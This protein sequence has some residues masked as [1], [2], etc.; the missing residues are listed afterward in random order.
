MP[1][2]NPSSRPCWTPPPTQAFLS[3]TAPVR[4][5]AGWTRKRSCG[6]LAPRRAAGTSR[7]AISRSTAARGPLSRL[8]EGT[9][10][11]GPCHDSVNHRNGENVNNSMSRPEGSH[12]GVNPDERPQIHTNGGTFLIYPD[13]HVVTVTTEKYEKARRTLA[14]CT[15][16][17][18]RPAA[19]ARQ[20]QISVGPK[21]NVSASSV[22]CARVTN[23]FSLTI[24]TKPLRG[25]DRRDGH[26][27]FVTCRFATVMTPEAT[28]LPRVLEALPSESHGEGTPGRDVG[29]ERNAQPGCPRCRG[30]MGSSTAS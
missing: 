25:N 3:L 2:S 29:P 14:R 7:P 17:D 23:G 4:S 13:G 15:F 5:A 28:R 9:T 27:S 11:P 12:T 10:T 16:E 24:Q 19:Q 30:T 20:R 26:E 1:L 22:S 6:I 21:T 8:Q 18:P